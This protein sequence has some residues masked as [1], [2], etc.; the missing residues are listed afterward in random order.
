MNYELKNAAASHDAAARTEKSNTMKNMGIS[1]VKY[2][3]V[4]EFLAQL[5]K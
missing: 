3:V 2:S 5:I 1:R 4:F